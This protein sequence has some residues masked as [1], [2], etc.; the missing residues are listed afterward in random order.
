MGIA[1][2]DWRI[3][4]DEVSHHPEL[5]SV[6]PERGLLVSLAPRCAD[7]PLVALHPVP[8]EILARIEAYATGVIPLVAL[9]T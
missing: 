1:Q 6:L 4:T 8:E 5:Y 2:E 9:G 3:V 7:T